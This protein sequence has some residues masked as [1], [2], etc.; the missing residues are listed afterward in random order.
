MLHCKTE[1]IGVYMRW[2]NLLMMKFRMLF[3]RA[4]AGEQLDA[5]MRFHLENQIAENRAAGM[6]ESEARC[7]SLRA[8]GNPA[9]LRDQTRASWSW[10]WLE[11]WWRDLHYSV[12]TLRR[13]PGF[14]TIA[15][16]VMALGIGANVALFTVVRS[17]LLKPLPFDEP[18]KLLMLYEK[19]GP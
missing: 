4:K 1:A 2:M 8:F 10:N 13:T 7:A 3:G 12:R 5:E 16:S 17:V 9:L 15:I 6:S 11:S 14:T 19:P 18:D